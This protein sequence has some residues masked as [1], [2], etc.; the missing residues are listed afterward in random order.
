MQ[1][2]YPRSFQNTLDWVLNHRQYLHLFP[3]TAVCQLW[4]DRRNSSFKKISVAESMFTFTEAPKRT[5]VL[6]NSCSALQSCS[7][8]CSLPLSASSRSAYQPPGTPVHAAAS[9]YT[10]VHLR[11]RFPLQQQQSLKS[12]SENLSFNF[13]EPLRAKLPDSPAPLG[14]WSSASSAPLVVTG[15]KWGALVRARQ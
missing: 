4:T 13:T 15:R 6:G 1:I 10:R 3:A 8:L 12:G 7:C 14:D 5:G 11:I 2:K 9:P